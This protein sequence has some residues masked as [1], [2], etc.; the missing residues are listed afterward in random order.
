MAAGRDHRSFMD[1]VTGGLATDG[2]R[3]GVSRLQPAGRA[4]WCGQSRVRELGD[5]DGATQTGARHN[6]V[7]RDVFGGV[8]DGA[9]SGISGAFPNWRDLSRRAPGR[10]PASAQRFFR[11]GA[12]IHASARRSPF[13]ALLRRARRRTSAGPGGL[14]APRFGVRVANGALVASFSV[15]DP[16]I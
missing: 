8:T 11:T 15:F 16:E 10:S 9:A 5:A 2:A 4:A 13:L 1:E 3:R 7:S 6:S 14:H 12:R